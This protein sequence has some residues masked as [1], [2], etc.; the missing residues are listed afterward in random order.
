MIWSWLARNR[1]SIRLAKCSKAYQ[2]TIAKTYV[3]SDS[4]L[5][6]KN[7][8]WSYCDT[9]KSKII[10][11]SENNHFKDMNR[12]DGMPT[13]FEWTIFPGITTLGIL[14]K[15]QTLMTDFQCEPEQ[16]KDRII[17]M[18]MY[19]DIEWKATGNKEQCEYNSQTVADYARR[20]PRG[21]RTFLEP[22]SE[23][24]VRDLFWQTRRILGS[25]CRN[26]DAPTTHRIRSPNISC[27]QCL[28]ERRMKKQRTW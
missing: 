22:G 3:F 25:N 11:Y 18:S 7:G 13:E 4:V 24:M 16:F 19:S 23:K 12:I 21:R 2:I 6:V 9:W 5:C 27:L 1:T 26:E 20:F 8:R 14:E 28:W 15:I 17:F 10:W